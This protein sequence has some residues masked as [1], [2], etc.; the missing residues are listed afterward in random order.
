MDLRSFDDEPRIAVTAKTRRDFYAVV[1][2]SKNFNLAPLFSYSERKGQPLPFPGLPTRGGLIVGTATRLGV[3]ELILAFEEAA[4]QL[5]AV[6]AGG[7]Q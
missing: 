3:E 1:F 5:R 7:E 6:V 2:H 4:K